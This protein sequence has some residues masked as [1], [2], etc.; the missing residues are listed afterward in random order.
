MLYLIQKTSKP[1]SLTFIGASNLLNLKLTAELKDSQ[2]LS[3]SLCFYLG[4]QIPKIKECT[5]RHPAVTIFSSV[6][7]ALSCYA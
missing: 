6:L 7:F 4:A 1:N 3:K 2:H 5:F